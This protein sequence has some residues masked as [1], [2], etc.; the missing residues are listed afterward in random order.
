MEIPFVTLTSA[1]WNVTATHCSLGSFSQYPSKEA[2]EAPKGRGNCRE[3]GGE[4]STE[5]KRRESRREKMITEQREKE[6]RCK[7][8]G[9]KC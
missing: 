9:L 4:V 8:K 2:E 1:G 3:K 7:R 5:N 6:G